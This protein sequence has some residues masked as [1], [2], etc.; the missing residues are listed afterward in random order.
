MLKW[1][2]NLMNWSG[3]LLSLIGKARG[4]TRGWDTFFRQNRISMMYHSSANEDTITQM[5]KEIIENRLRKNGEIEGFNCALFGKVTRDQ[6]I[7]NVDK[8]HPDKM[9]DIFFDLKREKLPVL[10][11]QDGLF[12]ECKPVDQKHP[13]FSCYCKKGLIRF[14]D[15]D[16][17]WAMQDA[18][19]VGYVKTPY[20]LKRFA[21]V[22]DDNK[23][24]K[25]LKFLFIETF[26]VGSHALFA[27]GLAEHSS[28]HI[29][30]IKMPGENFR[31]RMLGAAIYMADTI[32]RLDQYDGVIVTDL[33][34]L[35]DFKALVGPKCPPV[36]VYFHENQL[37]YPQAVGDKS[38]FLLGMINITTALAADRVVFNSLMHKEAFL[39]A[40]P[41]FLNRGRDFTPKGVA[42]K[43]R[44]KACMLYPGITLA[45][46]VKIDGKKQANPPLI[47]WNHRWGFDKNHQLFFTVL[48]ELQ[49]QGVDFQLALMGE[50]FGKIPEEFFEARHTFKDKIVVF[51]YVRSR[52]EY[53]QWLKRGTIVISTATQENFGMSVIEAMIMGCIPLLPNRLSYPEILPEKFHGKFLYKNKY[54]LIEKLRLIISDIKAYDKIQNELAREMEFFLWKNVV[55]FYDLE[56]EQLVMDVKQK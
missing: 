20:S 9:P 43:I 22:L 19:M 42:G 28:H 3:P 40:V 5:L 21:S 46:V 56:L 32:E 54:D 48:K 6:K 25:N 52:T 44:K 27:N 38:V 29:D 36:L 23:K 47:I 10:S 53:I 1:S 49:A 50:N 16:Y 37:T 17:A 15:G 35:A 31:W 4:C 11:D 18:L 30:I 39:N 12:V 45:P 8:K 41:T 2:V 26:Y 33:F 34:N 13:I 51:G 14:I 7:P 24:N 55:K